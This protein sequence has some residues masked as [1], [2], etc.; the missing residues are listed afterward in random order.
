MNYPEINL[1]SQLERKIRYYST[2]EFCQRLGHRF[3]NMG[4]SNRDGSS[5]TPMCSVCCC[6]IMGYLFE[7][8][9]EE[10]TDGTAD[11]H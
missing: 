10:A 5:W 11:Y 2:Y 7:S 6:D 9:Y 3:D 8:Q 1:Y 4:E